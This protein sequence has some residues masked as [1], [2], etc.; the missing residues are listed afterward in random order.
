MH[1]AACDRSVETGTICPDCFQPLT[2]PG[3]VASGEDDETYRR[4]KQAAA[5]LRAP[6]PARV[7]T[8][9][10]PERTPAAGP[11]LAWWGVLACAA[12]TATLLLWPKASAR[13]P[14]PVPSLNHAQQLLREKAYAEAVKEAKGVLQ[15]RSG[16]ARTA[17]ELIAAAAVKGGLWEDAVAQY[18]A[19]GQV[20]ELKKARRVLG[21]LKLDAAR[22]A[23]AAGN[24]V[25]ARDLAKQ[26]LALLKACQAESSRLATAYAI[27]GQVA[28]LLDQLPAAEGYLSQAVAMA[29]GDST[30]R[31]TLGKVR[32]RLAPTPAPRPAANYVP[33]VAREET[34]L[35][36]PSSRSQAAYPTYQPKPRYDEDGYTS[37]PSRTSYSEPV[38]ASTPYPTPPPSDYYPAA[39]SRRNRSSD[40]PTTPTSRVS[41][42]RESESLL[43]RYR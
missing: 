4:L 29:P 17:R 36:V 20:K 39:S 30:S 16:D 3:S 28:Y 24:V 5:P 25:Q 43:R 1:C 37:S 23:L 11:S 19:L 9:P 8:P 35:V 26:A 38:R 41:E 40:Y 27:L 10:P 6:I 7:Q 32:A 12:L 15:A 33:P 2:A 21:D 22:Q 34:V 13:P 31:A 18:Q 42:M 14:A